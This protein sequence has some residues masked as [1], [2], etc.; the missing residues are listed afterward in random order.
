MRSMP[1]AN[2]IINL[3]ETEAPVQM[4]LLSKPETTCRW[5]PKVLLGRDR[6]KVF[7]GEWLRKSSD[8]IVYQQQTQVRSGENI[9][10]IGSNRW[11]DYR[12]E[13]IISFL[14]HSIKPP[15]GGAILYYHFTN[16]NNYYCLHLCLEKQSLEIIKRVKGIWSTV[17]KHGFDCG[18]LKPYRI[19]IDTRS[20]TDS[21]LVD[22]EALVKFNKQDLTHGCVGIGVK[23]CN[24]SFSRASVSWLHPS[25]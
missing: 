5:V 21:F 6:W 15:E 7:S 8:E 25:E 14:D 4:D 18:I 24:V 20:G 17:F 13:A 11:S 16:M 12:F 2:S 3:I 9:S 1:N 10:V 22:G 23:Y 19:T